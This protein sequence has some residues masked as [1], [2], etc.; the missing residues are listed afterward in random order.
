METYEVWEITPF[1]GNKNRFV[2]SFVTLEDARL[3]NYAI[4]ARGRAS[5]IYKYGREKVED[6]C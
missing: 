6:E 5:D 2:A 3:F 1:T 4:C